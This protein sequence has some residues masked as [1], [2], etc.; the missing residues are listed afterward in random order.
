[1][2]TTEVF[3]ANLTKEECTLTGGYLEGS[4]CAT[5]QYVP[6]VFF[7]SCLLFFGTFALSTGLKSFRNTRFFPNKVRLGYRLLHAYV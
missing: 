3:W 6:N 5:P 4:G 7:F 2:N 1:M